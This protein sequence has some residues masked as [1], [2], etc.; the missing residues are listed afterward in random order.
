MMLR[1]PHPFFRPRHYFKPDLVKVRS[2]LVRVV[3]FL[4][5]LRFLFKSTTYKKVVRVVRVVR[6]NAHLLYT[7]A[8]VYL[9]MSFKSSFIEN[10]PDHLDQAR[11]I[12][13][14]YLDHPPCPTLTALTRTKEV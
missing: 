2:G 6:V 9:F 4:A 5:I 11:K 3:C 7:R 1:S 10:N 14:L 13:G 8:H 12:N